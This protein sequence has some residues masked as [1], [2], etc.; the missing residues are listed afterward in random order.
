MV[1]KHFKSIGV[2]SEAR[3]NPVTKPRRQITY[4]EPFYN[5]Q[6]VTLYSS[7]CVA[8]IIFLKPILF[9]HLLTIVK[10]VENILFVSHEKLGVQIIRSQL[11]GSNR[12][13]VYRNYTFVEPFLIVLQYF[14]RTIV[15]IVLSALKWKCWKDIISFKKL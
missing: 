12:S 14:I 13:N 15:P 2:K 7:I 3:F 11:R 9:D 10:L 1:D 6:I 8:V 4:F 5:P